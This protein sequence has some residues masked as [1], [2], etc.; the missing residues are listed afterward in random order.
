MPVDLG[1]VGSSQGNG[2]ELT[3]AQNAGPDDAEKDVTVQKALRKLKVQSSVAPGKAL[4]GP[5]RIELLRVLWQ[6]IS[7]YRRILN[8]RS[9]L[10]A[11]ESSP[12]T[13]SVPSFLS[14]SD[15]DWLT[16]DCERLSMFAPYFKQ[17]TSR[18]VID[19]DVESDR[20]HGV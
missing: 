3:T 11:S 19:N 20:N 8:P 14:D 9:M 7:L 12:E 17:F 15:R 18:E 5:N 6:S 10:S 1:F 4:E 13:S 16:K 2:R